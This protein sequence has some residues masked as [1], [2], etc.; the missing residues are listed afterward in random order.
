MICSR[1][2]CGW[3]GGPPRSV[4]QCKYES[5]LAEALDSLGIPQ[6]ARG[7]SRVQDFGILVR[8]TLPDNSE[9]DIDFAERVF[10]ENGM[11]A[12]SPGVLLFSAS[13]DSSCYNFPL[14]LDHSPH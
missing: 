5:D 3:L 7:G 1:W 13:A 10:H 2:T 14:K 4:I 11:P 6:H 9:S 8:P 12:C